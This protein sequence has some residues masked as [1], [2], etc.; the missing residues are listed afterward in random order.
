MLRYHEQ[1][2]E[3]QEILGSGGGG[4]VLLVKNRH[5]KNL[6]VIKVL[7]RD[8]ARDERYVKRFEE[9]ACVLAGLND[10]GLVK[11]LQQ[12]RLSDPVGLPFMQMEYIEGETLRDIL[13]RKKML[14]VEVRLIILIQVF[15]TLANSHKAGIIHRDIKPENILIVESPT[16]LV[17]KI[18]DFGIFLHD[19]RAPESGSFV[20]TICYA[21]PEQLRGFDIDGKSDIYSVGVIAYEMSTGKRPFSDVYD[22]S[23]ESMCKTI[24]IKVLPLV[25][26]D[27]SIPIEFSEFVEA[28]LE[29]DV[30]MRPTAE[31]G[32]QRGK[33]VQQQLFVRH[34]APHTME[35][36]QVRA[37]E[38]ERIDIE[39]V[40]NRTSPDGRIS[41]FARED[42]GKAETERDTAHRIQQ[43]GDTDRMNEHESG[44]RTRIPDGSDPPE[45]PSAIA[46]YLD[47]LG[48][49]ESPNHAIVDEADVNDRVRYPT[50]ERV[51]PTVV[52][53][54]ED[55]VYDKDDKMVVAQ[56]GDGTLR[57]GD[58][59][60][61]LPDPPNRASDLGDDHPKGLTEEELRVVCGALVDEAVRVLRP[62]LSS[63]TLEH[64]SIY[65]RDAAADFMETLRAKPFAEAVQSIR[66]E[67]AEVAT[68]L[69]AQRQNSKGRA[70]AMPEPP[71]QEAGAP[72]GSDAPATNLPASSNDASDESDSSEGPTD[73][74]VRA[75]A[76]ELTDEAISVLRADLHG[77]EALLVV[78]RNYEAAALRELRAGPFEE[79]VRRI[80]TNI[81]EWAAKRQARKSHADVVPDEELCAVCEELVD[82]AAR[83]LMP[84][85]TSEER[86][87]PRRKL[88]GIFITSL[89]ADPSEENIRS[90]REM[91]ATKREEMAAE[92]ARILNEPA[93]ATLA[94][95]V[96]HRKVTWKNIAIY[97]L[98]LVIS[99]ILAL[100][101]FHLL[102]YF[103]LRS[104][105]THPEPGA[106]PPPLVEPA[107]RTVTPP[108]PASSASATEV[109]PPTP[110][111]APSAVKRP[112]SPA[113]SSSARETDESLRFY[114]KDRRTR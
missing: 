58:G 36:A 62:L 6:S 104:I 35:D 97:G 76:K 8:L 45:S 66:A 99:S 67:I 28:L 101:V 12:G 108:S 87:A 51:E 18:F 52:S 89:R 17:V 46:A 64:M 82:E 20:G 94:P 61:Q 98:L 68:E 4:Q 105:L 31:A 81:A 42:F 103:D 110:K 44:E 55:R 7:H 11:V 3:I 70:D 1:Q 111:I 2:Y 16:G 29:K 26:V 109:L 100:G 74:E 30:S 34:G 102:G 80:R 24:G 37:A 54:S 75:M 32:K 9:E 21:S 92:R 41:T 112:V 78:R 10:P 13:N 73:E 63:Y 83:V 93:A 43:S 113:S 40:E 71:Q 14:P 95:V 85:S 114:E 25:S 53:Q 39:D 86:A 47:S 50:T 27:P 91:I 65:R 19:E 107:A 33:A 59:E 72:E 57:R 5:L 56:R 84:N 38:V 88:A 22:G 106:A 77:E 69:A 49:S 48:S 15:S 90:I 60:V 79:V 23:F 96:S